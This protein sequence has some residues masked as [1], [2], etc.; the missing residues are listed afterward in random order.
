MQI[1]ELARR[2]GIAPSAIR[3]YEA[4]GLL[5]RPARKSGRRVYGADALIRVNLIRIAQS[6][7]FTLRETAE[8][9]QSGGAEG[10]RPAK[11]ESLVERKISQIDAK[12][13]ELH[14]AREFLT[15]SKSC[16]CHGPDD[17]ALY[18]QSALPA[19]RDADVRKG[20]N[21]QGR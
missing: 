19:G 2:A 7:G 5:P 18:A 8:L 17:C 10:W 11:F 9:L 12:L 15:R 13:E 1:G 20:R 16:N 6:A 4:A 3:Y 21:I 14:F